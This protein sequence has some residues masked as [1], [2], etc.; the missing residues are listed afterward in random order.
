MRYIALTIGPI[1]KTL[2]NAKKL[3]NFGVEVIFLVTS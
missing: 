3:E 1:Y 2:K